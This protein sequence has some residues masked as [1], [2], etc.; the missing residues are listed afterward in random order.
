MSED[1]YNRGVCSVNGGYKC[2]DVI[3]G[4]QGQIGCEPFLN[5]S[6]EKRVVGGVALPEQRFVLTGL[7]VLFGNDK[8]HPGDIVYFDGE[9]CASVWGKREYTLDGKKFVLAPVDQVRVVKRAH[10]P[11]IP[12]EDK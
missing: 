5:H 2:E 3:E 1:N 6:M 12:K 11:T 10:L 9:A 8:Y 4:C 7:K